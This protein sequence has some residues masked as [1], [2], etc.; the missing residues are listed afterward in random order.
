VSA[1]TQKLRQPSY[2]DGVDQFRLSD[3]TEVE[4]RQIAAD[5]GDRLRTAHGRLSPEA[6]YRRFLGAKPELTEADA[7]YLV[8][9]DG[10][11]HYALVA[12]TN[13]DGERGAIIAV[14]RFVRATDEPSAAE[15]AIV[16]G[17]AY[18]R[19]GL[20]AALIERLAAAAVERGISRFRATMLSDNVAIFRL[21]EQ[22]SASEL[23][24]VNRGAISEVEVELPAT[25][26]VRATDA[27]AM[28][29]GCPGS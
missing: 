2:I 27:R 10:S 6:R 18:Q 21:L 11:D 19:Q 22:L 9:I 24:L 15:F 16:V 29:A 12:T 23:Q 13:L 3:G 7:R 5:D 4:V 25:V 8:E 28:I 26:H 20:A 1:G 17:D 14:A